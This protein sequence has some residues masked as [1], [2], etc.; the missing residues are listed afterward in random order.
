MTPTRS[1][2]PSKVKLILRQI[3]EVSYEV[4]VFDIEIR[5]FPLLIL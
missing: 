3:I 5:E 1:C 4:D 2:N